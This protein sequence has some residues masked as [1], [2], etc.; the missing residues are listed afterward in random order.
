MAQRDMHSFVKPLCEEQAEALGLELV[1]VE[2]V[3]EGPGKTLRIYINKEGGVTLSDCEAYH[4]AVQ[5]RL[6]SVD[7][8]FMEVSSPGLDRPLKTDRD[9][10]RAIDAEVEVRLF[11]PLEGKKVFEG[12]LL[13]FDENTFTI[14][15]GLRERGFTRR[16][17]A[18]VKPLIRFEEDEGVDEQ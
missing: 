8:D 3:K 1:D 12:V 17:V 9:F 13:R 7:Y 4:R 16:E 2:L 6:E 18:L 11:T 14:M 5:P 10:L 15:D